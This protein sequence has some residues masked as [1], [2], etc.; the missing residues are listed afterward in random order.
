MRNYTKKSY[1]FTACLF[2]AAFSFAQKGEFCGI[3]NKSFLPGEKMAEMKPSDWQEITEHIFDELFKK[4]AVERT[5]ITGLK[6]N[7][8][9]VSA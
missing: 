2:F 5:K 3:K 7:I 8:N 1:L 9:F 6:R 4:S